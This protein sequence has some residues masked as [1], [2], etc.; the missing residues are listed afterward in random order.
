M[1]LYR[2]WIDCKFFIDGM[3]TNVSPN[4]WCH[5]CQGVSYFIWNSMNT[6]HVKD[7]IIQ[8]SKSL[9]AK[10]LSRG[11]ALYQLETWMNIKVQ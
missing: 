3:K 5:M 8:N 9:R 7:I 2:L 10:Y 6:F 4:V 1:K 11:D